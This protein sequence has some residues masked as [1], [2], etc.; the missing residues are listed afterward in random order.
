MTVTRVPLRE[1]YFI[2]EE[3]GKLLGSKCKVCGQ[4]YFPPRDR[5]FT[6]FSSEMEQIKLSQTGKLYTYTI[7][8]MPVAKYKP[9]LA[10]AWVELP[11]GIR[12]FTQLKG[13][14]NVQLKIGMP[15]KLVLDTLWT[16]ENKEVYGYKFTPVT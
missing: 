7:V 1:G 8:R 11:E 10:L 2:E 3:G 16:E 14:E 6:C 4:N 9:P 15:V 12:V 5:C 13:W